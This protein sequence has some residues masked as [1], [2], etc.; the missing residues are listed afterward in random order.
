MIRSGGR[1]VSSWTRRPGEDAEGHPVSS[2]SLKPAGIVLL[3]IG[4]VG[5][6][7]ATA[8]TLAAADEAYVIRL[9]RPK[10][11]G[12]RYRLDAK[13]TRRD[14][15]RLTV[16]GQP[17]GNEEKELS[18]HLVAAAK[19]LAVDAKSNATKIEYRVESCRKKTTSGQTTETE[20]LPAGRKVIVESIGGETSFTTDPGKTLDTD[21]RDALKVVLSAHEPDSPTDD[22]IFG[23]RER[24]RVGD[25]WALNAAAAARDLSKKGLPVSAADVKGS[26]RLEGERTL[27]ATKALEITARFRVEGMKVPVPE[28]TKLEKSVMEAVYNGLFPADPQSRDQ[29][30]EKLKIQMNLVMSGQKPDTGDKIVVDISMEMSLENG[31]AP[32][33]AAR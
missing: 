8:S 29:L 5:A 11:V 1:E 28:G 20:V 24:Q 3:A 18:V 33:R 13:G 9:A 15:Q 14:S 7:G 4:A 21:T 16:G 23:T 27:D 12:D 6:M 31:Y 32:V 22:D 2:K 25:T 17:I 26:V 19:V 10:K 30:P